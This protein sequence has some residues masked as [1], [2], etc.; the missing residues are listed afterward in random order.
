[1]DVLVDR[2]PVA[3]KVA[4]R[5]GVVVRATPEFEDVA[6]VAAELDRPVQDV[7]AAAVAATERA[8]LRAGAPVTSELRPTHTRSE[9]AAEPP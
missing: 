5:E 3:V 9:K 4:H 1:V 2:Q 6:R 7:L 8:E